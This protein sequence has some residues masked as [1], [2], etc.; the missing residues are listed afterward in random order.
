M[1]NKTKLSFQPLKLKVWPQ[2]VS[3][4]TEVKM[5]SLAKIVKSSVFDLEKCYIPQKNP[6]K[7]SFIS[8]IQSY[9]IKSAP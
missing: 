9:V 4:V 6:H 3:E 2:K 1:N 5:K 7:M 8:E